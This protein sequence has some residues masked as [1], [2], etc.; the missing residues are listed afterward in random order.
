MYCVSGE[1]ATFADH[2]AKAIR[3]T[4]LLKELY[5]AFVRKHLPSTAFVHFRADMQVC[6][7]LW[8]VNGRGLA[9]STASLRLELPSQWWHV[10]VFPMFV[11]SERP[12][13]GCMALVSQR[14]L[15]RGRPVQ[16]L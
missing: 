2:C 16:R 15:H 8:G 6:V 4:G 9:F 7:G 3:F 10:A 11:F 12:H 1:E 14:L 5:V 13:Y